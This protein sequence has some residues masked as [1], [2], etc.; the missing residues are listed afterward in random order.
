MKI[1]YLFPSNLICGGHIEALQ[2]VTRLGD[3]GHEVS[4]CLLDETISADKNSFS[5][6]PDF[7]ASVF[8]PS[9]FPD[10]VD[11][12]VATF[13]TTAFAS[14]KLPAR[15]KV[16]FVQCDESQFY[17]DPL[18]KS[19]VALSYLCNFSFMTEAKWVVNWLKNDFGHDC[20]YVPKGID[21]TKMILTAPVE[22]KPSHKRRVLIEGSID[23]P[24]KRV[25]ESIEVCQEI[26]CEVWCVSNKGK[27][28][29]GLRVDRFFNQVPFCEMNQIYSSCDILLKLSSVE[30]VFAPPLEMMACGGVPIVSDVTGYDEYIIDEYNA[31]VVPGG[32]VT[33]A[34]HALSRLIND[35]EL[36]TKLQK[37]GLQTALSR[38]WD[39]SIDQ[40]E[41]FFRHL[42]L[43]TLPTQ[44]SPAT[45]TN[46]VNADKLL[47]RAWVLENSK[48][49]KL[50]KYLFGIR[51]KF[52]LS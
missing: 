15:Q 5:W 26:E 24:F 51:G 22:P 19:R 29:H 9:D 11:I 7:S 1:V 10:D 45:V 28:P 20:F 47:E 39:P 3:R 27:L 16:Y 23:S 21:T 41:I 49:G 40:L 44:I 18:W 12:S 38:N 36:Y 33:L 34:C 37:N 2:H 50:V 17:D 52:S 8:H 14:L 25:K 43:E 31:L 35:P 48:T 30:G 4:I 6:F 46:I 42:H 32:D 13:W